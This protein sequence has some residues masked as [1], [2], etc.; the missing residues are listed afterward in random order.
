MRPAAGRG[1]ASWLDGGEPEPAVRQGGDGQDGG[2]LK[3]MAELLSRLIDYQMFSILLLDAS[4]EK[5]QHRFS[6]RFQERLHRVAGAVAA[7][8]MAAA[9]M[10][11]MFGATKLDPANV[12]RI[13]EIVR[14]RGKMQNPVTGSGGMLLGRVRE[15]GPEHPASGREELE[16]GTRRIRSMSSVAIAIPVAASVIP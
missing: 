1:H 13:Q 3:R 4:G 8:M 5:L 12:A 2:D 6:Q 14:S 9:R 15:V 10:A 16:L 11:G 7:A